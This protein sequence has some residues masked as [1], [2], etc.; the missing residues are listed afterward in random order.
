MLDPKAKVVIGCTR[1]IGKI[2]AFTS[3]PCISP[4]SSSKLA[5]SSSSYDASSSK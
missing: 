5:H 4:T 3:T 1:L 2:L